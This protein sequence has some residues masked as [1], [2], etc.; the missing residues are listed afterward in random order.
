MVVAMHLGEYINFYKMFKFMRKLVFTKYILVYL[1]AISSAILLI[2]DILNL[3]LFQFKL[4]LF[5]DI[6]F[7]IVTT[8]PFVI[9]PIFVVSIL[10]VFKNKIDNFKIYYKLLY[11]AIVILASLSLLKIYDDFIYS[12]LNYGLWVFIGGI[13]LGMN[14]LSYKMK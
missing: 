13:C 7:L 14:L 1:I 8:I 10:G 11:I 4:G 5:G 12:N 2:G 9:L 6:A 3:T